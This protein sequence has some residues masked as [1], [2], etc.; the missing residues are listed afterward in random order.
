MKVAVIILNYNTFH[1]CCKC[2]SFLKRQ[3]GVELE[4]I[5]VDNCSRADDVE[6]LRQLCK[7]QDCI[8]IENHENRG[9]NAGNNIG[10]RYA[11]EKG[12]KYALIANPDMEFPATNYIVT[13]VATISQDSNVVVIG[14]NIID[15]DGQRQSPRKFTTYY[16]ELFWIVNG[17]KKILGKK[18]SQILK[19]QNQYCDILM[20]SCIMVDIDFIKKI[21]FFDE[22]VFLYCEEPI[23]GKQVAA[24]GK[25]MYYYHD[26][27]AVH[28]HHENTKG[29]FVKR[30][31]LYWRSRW[32]YLRY[33]TNYNSSQMFFMWVSKKLFY[34]IKRLEFIFRGK[35]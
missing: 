24:A 9:Y 13:L 14:S 32:Y 2:V 18:S 15:A 17:L 5:I 28:A 29:S 12:Y 20:G 4:I 26:I 33:Y 21:G 31:D 30:H 7:E 10:L 6:Q 23:L 35:K 19:P 11:A 8:F 25:K 27:T 16:E 22:R 1:D 3:T 34:I